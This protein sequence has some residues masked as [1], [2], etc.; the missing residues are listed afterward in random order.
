MLLKIIIFS[1]NFRIFLTTKKTQIMNQ[2]QTDLSL[3]E[4]L[5]LLKSDS[6]QYPKCLLINEVGVICRNEEDASG[7]GEEYLLSAI[8]SSHIGTKTIAFC[9][10]S[11]ISGVQ[12][13]RAE[14][15]NDFRTNPEN[16]KFLPGVDQAI[17][18]FQAKSKD[19]EVI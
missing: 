3:E 1:E 14:E 4:I 2:R 16:Q 6:D 8:N 11:L 12:E 13:R 5:D 9:C 7:L 10:L 17:A 19:A 18:R 15:I